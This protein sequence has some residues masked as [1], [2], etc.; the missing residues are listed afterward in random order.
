MGGFFLVFF[1]DLGFWRG[2]LVGIVSFFVLFLSLP[3]AI[4]EVYQVNEAGDIDTGE[5]R[6]EGKRKQ[7]RKLNL[8]PDPTITSLPCK[9][10]GHESYIQ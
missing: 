6:A 9:E 3:C 2:C 7:N 5:N 10:P 8:Y 4:I 1:C